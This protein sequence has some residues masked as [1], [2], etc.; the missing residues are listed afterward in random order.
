MSSS[1]PGGRGVDHPLGVLGDGDVAELRHGGPAEAGDLLDERV[2]AAPAF[3][4]C[5]DDLLAAVEHAGGLLVGDRDRDTGGG[6]VQGDGPAHAVPLAAAGDER[7][8][9]GQCDPPE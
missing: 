5:A 7:D 2:N 4:A 9:S 8:S 3:L 6:E 1:P